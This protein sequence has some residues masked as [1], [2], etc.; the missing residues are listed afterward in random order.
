MPKVSKPVLHKAVGQ[1]ACRESLRIWGRR[2]P[3]I[4]RNLHNVE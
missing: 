3:P 1:R 2:D 4:G